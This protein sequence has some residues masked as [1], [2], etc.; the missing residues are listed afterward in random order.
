MPVW[1][2]SPRAKSVSMAQRREGRAIGHAA[3]N[4][5][6]ADS[7]PSVA[8]SRVQIPARLSLQLRVNCVVEVVQSERDIDQNTVDEKSRHAAHAAALAGIH[9][10]VYPLP[11][12]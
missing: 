4:L 9:M 11:V 8:A 2:G 10:L 1:A 3:G 12:D 7:F 6:G 5:H